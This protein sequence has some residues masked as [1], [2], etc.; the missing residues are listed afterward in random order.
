MAVVAA[1]GLRSYRKNMTPKISIILPVYN[2]KLYLQATL[3]SL[4][5][6][7]FTDFE[8]LAI[9]DGSTD[10]SGDILSSQADSRLRVL[11]NDGNQGLAFS[12]NRGL[13]EAKGGY[14]ARMDS[15]DL[16][17]PDRL[18]K[19]LDFLAARPKVDICG[20]SIE[21]VDEAGHIYRRVDYPLTDEPIKALMIF[22]SPL[23]HPSVMFRRSLL[24][25][26]NLYYKDVAGEDYELWSRLLPNITFAN[27]PEYLLAYRA[28]VGR[29]SH[30]VKL[31]TQDES[32]KVQL[33]L[34]TSYF[35][36]PS[37][38]EAYIHH[39][40]FRHPES[41]SQA[42]IDCYYHWLLKLQQVNQQKKVFTNKIFRQTLAD[43]WFSLIKL[44]G[45]RQL[46][47]IRANL[48][49]NFYFFLRLP[50]TK[51]LEFIQALFK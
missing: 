38:D 40:L 12:L 35:F 19:Q 8:I 21:L 30:E 6:Q 9:N 44:Y 7:T 11:N 46:F 28:G 33:K 43:Q 25:N 13:S 34:L 48:F 51:Q 16:S 26:E 14:I 45:N 47:Y 41:Y 2:A 29:G 17:R 1:F 32:K 20:S 37:A 49:Y 36:E 31:E 24:S 22:R 42:N 27:C 39:D 3:D 50:F 10:G 15:D 5:Q 23:V 4:Y 18:Q